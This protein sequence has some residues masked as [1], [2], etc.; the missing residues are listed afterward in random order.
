MRKRNCSQNALKSRVLSLVN[1]KWFARDD[2]DLVGGGRMRWKIF[3]KPTGF[4]LND[5]P[6][7]FE[8]GSAILG[9]NYRHP[10][11]ERL[12]RNHIFMTEPWWWYI[13]KGKSRLIYSQSCSRPRQHFSVRTVMNVK[14]F[15]MFSPKHLFSALWLLFG[16]T[17]VFCSSV[18]RFPL[19]SQ[20]E[21][22]QES[23]R[24]QIS[25]FMPKEGYL[26]NNVDMIPFV[27]CIARSTGLPQPTINQVLYR[28]ESY[29]RK[30]FIEEMLR[31]IGSSR[32]GLQADRIMRRGDGRIEMFFI[33]TRYVLWAWLRM[34][35]RQEKGRPRPNFNS[36]QLVRPQASPTMASPEAGP[37]PTASK[38]TSNGEVSKLVSNA[39]LLLPCEA[40]TS[41]CFLDDGD[42]STEELDGLGGA[43]VGALEDVG[44]SFLRFTG[45]LRRFHG[46][47]KRFVNSGTNLLIG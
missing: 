44:R 37:K 20:S 24:K 15:A 10:P 19:E 42:A 18:V 35:K 29:T 30:G 5:V 31:C 12:N 40:V 13:F 17:T 38:Q 1:R 26:P 33:R 7:I 21:E 36:G 2:L 11:S 9:H 27:D 45:G 46:D 43:L 16:V 22:V 23:V 34:L 47:F 25:S 4:G 28:L 8:R 6:L 41:P 3:Q 32:P 39:D 14:M